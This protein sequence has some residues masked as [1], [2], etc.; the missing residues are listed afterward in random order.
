MSQVKENGYYE[1]LFNDET[2][3]LIFPLILTI[4]NHTRTHSLSNERNLISPLDRIWLNVPHKHFHNIL[5]DQC[6]YIATHIIFLYLRVSL[7]DSFE[8]A[9]F[10]DKRNVNKSFS[11]KNAFE[12]VAISQWQKYANES[13][14][15]T[16]SEN[17]VSMW[18]VWEYCKHI[19]HSGAERKTLVWYIIASDI[20]NK[21][22]I[23]Y[24]YILT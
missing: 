18:F 15:K 3:E 8:W 19:I 6:C 1:D 12:T 23:K 22:M 5:F 16:V 14:Y 9:C 21:H 10:P 2:P 4:I 13:L 20:N 11:K 17:I 7:I 24:S